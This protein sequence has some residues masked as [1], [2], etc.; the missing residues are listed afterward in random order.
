MDLARLHFLIS[1][2]SSREYRL[3]VLKHP[4]HC[5]PGMHAPYSRSFSVSLLIPLSPSRRR[6]S[7]SAPARRTSLL[8][9]AL[10]PGLYS[11]FPPACHIPPP[12]LTPSL[13]SLSLSLLSLQNGAWGEVR[14][15]RTLL[16]GKI[17]AT[18]I[19]ERDTAVA[20]RLSS[21]Y[22]RRCRDSTALEI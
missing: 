19:R 2:S 7:K 11:A 21:F 18:R 20:T 1:L 17:E 16:V 22:L 8:T 15:E 13:P 6:T 5:T 10:H 12:S 9:F 3:P 14:F 4:V